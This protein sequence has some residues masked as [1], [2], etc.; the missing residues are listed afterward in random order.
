MNA[1]K[2]I[3]FIGFFLLGIIE[4]QLYAQEIHSFT[5]E[6][7]Q[8]YAVENSYMAR[9]AQYDVEESEY[10]VKET[11]AMGL[12]QV[13]G[14]VD[15]NYN[16]AL[17]VQLI[18]AEFVGGPPG[19][20]AEIVFG[21][22][23]TLNASATLSQLIFDGTYLIGLKGAKVYNEL[24]KQQKGATDFEVKKNTADAY[25]MAIVAVE[26]HKMLVDNLE[27]IQKQLFETTKLY[28]NGLVEEQNVDQLSL[29]EGKVRIEVDNALRQMVISRNMLKYQMGISLSD[30]LTL[31]D[32][33]QKLIDNAVIEITGRNAYDVSQNIQY[34]VADAWVNVRD[35][36]T[37]LEKAKYL[38]SLS[39]M[40]FV[41]GFSQDD[42]FNAFN[43]NGKWYGSSFIGLNMKIPIFSGMGRYNTVQKAEVVS[44]RMQVQREELKAGLELELSTAN[45]NFN[46]SLAAFNIS[47]RNVEVA[48]KIRDKTYR[49]FQEG[50]ASSFEVTQAESQL[51]TDQF[52]LVGAALNL[53]EAKTKIDQ[54]LNN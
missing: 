39:G 40:M 33:I 22:K 16:I 37:K 13:N 7:A 43:A 8:V 29:N 9:A 31:V 18:P 38:P 50:I 27:E 1:K 41:Q 21:T 42:T 3:V 26:N 30:S 36:Q 49:K 34:K 48:K 14:K 54:I 10:Q 46:Q 20:F 24:V 52:N 45:A 23:H 2:G 35:M 15:Y 28:E 11:M 4:F 47:L 6:E 25:Y 53:F 44:L 17:P 51:I 32:D 12:P 5:L 19:E